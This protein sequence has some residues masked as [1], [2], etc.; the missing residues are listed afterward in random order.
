MP[1][2]IRSLLHD[3]RYG[4]R[5]L[6]KSPGFTLA[7][8]LSLA[9]GIGA[10]TA[11][12]SVIYA[13]LLRPL[14][15]PEP[16]RLVRVAQHDS[17]DAV[18]MPEYDFWKAHASAFASVAAHR[19]S[20]DASFA[21]AEGRGWVKAMPVTTDFLRTLGI[22][23]AM[24]RE[25]QSEETRPTGPQA[26]ILTEGLW[27]RAFH[28]DA[29]AL[30]RSLTIGDVSYTV[31]GVLPRGF[32]FPESADAF[33][34]LRPSRTSADQGSNTEMIARLKPDIGLPQAEA[35]MGALTGSFRNASHADADYRGLTVVPYQEWLTGDVRLKLVLLFGAV[36]LLL[37]IACV[38]LSGLLLARFEARQKEIAV[39][40][41]LGCGSGRL[42]RQFFFENA[43]LGVAGSLVGLLGAAWFLD[44]LVALIPFGNSL[45]APVRLDVPVLL[46]TFAIALGTAFVFSLAPYVSTRRFDIYETLRAAG[47]SIG[48]GGARHRTRSFLVV[49][50]VA[51][52]VTLLVAA[53]LLIQSLYRMHQERLGFTPHGLITFWIPPAPHDQRGEHERWNF[54]SALLERLGVVPGVRSVA[55]V[56]VLPLTDPNNFPAEREGH[57]EQD[58]SVEIRHVTPAY[59]ETM[60]IPVLRGRPFNSRDA[61]GAQP[62]IAVNEALA[63]RWWPQANPLGDRIVVGR[64]QGQ[65]AGELNESPREVVAI[66]G[67]TKSVYLKEPPRPTVYLPHTPASWYTGDML[68]IVRADLSTDLAARLRQAVEELDSHRRVEHL[69][70]MDEIVASTTAD[71]RSDASLFGTFAVLALMLTAMGIYG[72]LSFS[73]VRRT[74]E[75]GTRMALG[76]SRPDVLK[77][78]LRQGFTLVAI[79]LLAGLSGALALTRYLSGLLFGVRPADPLS[80][81]AVSA[82]LLSVGLLASYLPARRATKVDPMVALR[83]E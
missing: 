1:E 31:V 6:R 80:F 32:W 29:G 9:L 69:Q 42:L 73:V 72:L 12:F 38:N 26:I 51:L 34:P 66:V 77:L 74:S 22:A 70:T 24:G 37:L 49:S 27:Q 39:R 60:G 28:E 40:L 71:T 65:D 8:I 50:E 3:I 13:V 62:V 41:A 81:V 14:P 33:V 23:P 15:Y 67:D 59:F 63:R 75:F 47:R 18:S 20:E 35:E 19:G 56:N 43:M 78:V 7:A 55:S 10:N 53:A 58:I 4:L 21:S 17:L 46:F 68:W 82:V 45:A 25:F 76:A 16:G 57:P 36:G 79:G 2:V 61:S 48:A 83:N 5:T 11:V 30:G 64:H 52:S 44:G 54:E